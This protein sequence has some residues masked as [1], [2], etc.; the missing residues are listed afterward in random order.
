METSA[1]EVQVQLSTRSPGSLSKNRHARDLAG[2]WTQVLTETRALFS[3]AAL[4][5]DK[6]G[7][8]IRV[9]ALLGGPRAPRRLGTRGI[10]TLSE[11]RVGYGSENGVRYGTTCRLSSPNCRH[12]RMFAAAVVGANLWHSLAVYTPTT[13]SSGL[14]FTGGGSGRI[15][16][17]PLMNGGRGKPANS[18]TMSVQ[19]TSRSWL[20]WRATSTRW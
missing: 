19:W 2:L 4:A 13:L 11:T 16:T 17:K 5:R 12:C 10:R 6:R 20:G 1:G 9:R 8:R 14:A 3:R 18:L 15:S 7:G